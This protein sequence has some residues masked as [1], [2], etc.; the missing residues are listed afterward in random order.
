MKLAASDL[1]PAVLAALKPY[2]YYCRK[3][4][5][6]SKSTMEF[7]TSPVSRSQQ[8]LNGQSPEVEKTKTK[9]KQ[10]KKTKKT[11]PGCP[12]WEVEALSFNT[13]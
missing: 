1:R 12:R 3:T 2:Y 13:E 5:N 6:L 8:S 10:N 7:V 9:K 11:R 4:D